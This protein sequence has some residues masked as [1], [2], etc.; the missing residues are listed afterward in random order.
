MRLIATVWIGS[1]LG[2][3]ISCG[4]SDVPTGRFDILIENGSVIDG[5]GREAIDADI[6]V[7]ADTIA[8][9]G[10][11]DKSKIEVADV[12]DAR[13]KL[14][15]PGFIDAHAHGDPIRDTEFENFLRMGVT[16]ICL[17]QDGFSYPST[18]YNAW[19]DSVD[20]AGLGVNVIYFMGH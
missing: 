20:S 2:L 10:K 14:I 11:V 1:I 8:Y 15:S 19:M 18:D 5:T 7:R 4:E 3:L 6:L 16:T 13:G 17:G 9:I 12:F